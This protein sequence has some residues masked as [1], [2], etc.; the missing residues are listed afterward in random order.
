MKTKRFIVDQL[1]KL[2]TQLD[3][4]PTVMKDEYGRWRVFRWGGWGC[5]IGLAKLSG[6]LD[7]LWQTGMWKNI[8]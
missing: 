6:F 4:L 2:D 7:E 5:R 8:S 3:N 1:E